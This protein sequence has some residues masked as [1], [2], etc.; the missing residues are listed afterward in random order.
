MAGPTVPCWGDQS[1]QQVEAL[2][3][4]L[5]YVYAG[6]ED[7]GIAPVEAMASGTR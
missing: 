7:F 4:L 1:Q 5:A 6:L 3:A 2:M